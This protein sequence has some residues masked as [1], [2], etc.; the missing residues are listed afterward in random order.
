MADPFEV[1]HRAIARKSDLR[2]VKVQCTAVVSGLATVTL[3]GQSVAGVECIGA[4]PVANTQMWVL[5]DGGTV[6]GLT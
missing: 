5:M 1:L 3:R 4:G 2:L 6:L